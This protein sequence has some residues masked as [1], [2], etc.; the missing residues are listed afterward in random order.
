MKILLTLDFPPEIGGIQRYL[1]NIVRHTY[2]SED[3]VLAGCRHAIADTGIEVNVRTEWLSTPF[4]RWNKKFSLFPM[5][6][7]YLACV[8]AK[9]ELFEVE[10]GNVYAAVVPWFACFMT[11][12]SY[13]VYTY[14]TELLFLRKKSMRGTVLRKI[15]GNSQ[16]IFAIGAYTASLIREAGFL[17]DITIVPPKI[18]LTGKSCEHAAA[19][20]GQTGIASVNAMRILCV[21]RL[22]PHKGHSVLLNAVA[23]LPGD[24]S[25]RLVIVGD[26]P[27]YGDLFDLCEA[28]NIQKRVLF[29]KNISQ[30]ELE[31]EYERASLFVLPSLEQINGVEGFGIVLLEAMAFGV[32]IIASCIGGI[33]EVLD[34]GSCGVLVEAGNSVALAH[35]IITLNDDAMKRRSLVT[36]AH[37]RVKEHYAWR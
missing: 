19:S 4:S 26:G 2:G 32:P 10:C 16:K 31:R 11:G 17:N 12:I 22:V 6:W 20:K 36:A 9:S 18:I 34:D 35:A 1:F 15:L 8:F 14:G 24:K 29:K 3:L 33:P 27:S 7:K 30:E 13:S 28:K 21:G 23:M 5:L 37:E 25:W